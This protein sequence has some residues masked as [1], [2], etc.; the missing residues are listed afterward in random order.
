MTANVESILTKKVAKTFM[1]GF[2]NSRVL[3]KAVNTALLSKDFADGD[4]GTKVYYPRP[5]DFNLIRTADGD[6]TGQSGAFVVGSSFGEVQPFFTVYADW[7]SLDDAIRFGDSLDDILNPAY[8]RLATG[9]ESAL[10][11]F[12]MTNSGLSV[13]TPG[14]VVDTWKKV[15]QADAQAVS[16]GWPGGKKYYAMNPY[17]SAELASAQSGLN[18][19]SEMVEQ[20]WKNAQVTTGIAGLTAL[21]GS[22]LASYTT[23]AG[24]DRAGTLSSTPTATFVSV[25]DTMIQSIPVTAFQAN[26]VVRKGEQVQV[27]TRPRIALGTRQSFVDGAGAK[28]VWRGT[29]TADVTLGAS[30]EGTLLVAGPAIF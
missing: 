29:V 25:K 18:Q 2:E 1:E 6:L 8:S 3:S 16:M 19:S 12:M 27:A 14:T 22:T 15:A 21:K 23:S 13:G 5:T 4:V 9:M 26:L 7:N 24:A 20:A 30:G 28:V 10:A 11:S 17:V